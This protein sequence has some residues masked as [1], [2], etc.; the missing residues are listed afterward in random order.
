MSSVH[1]P[2]VEQA[3]RVVTPPQPGEESAGPPL[4]PLVALDDVARRIAEALGAQ[5]AAR[6]R[7]RE[8]FDSVPF[9]FDA[10]GDVT[11]ANAVKIW[12]VPQGNIGYLMR[13]MIEAGGFTPA[14]PYQ[15]AGAW[16]GIWVGRPSPNALTGAT[17]GGLVDYAP[18]A[19]GGPIFPALF[20]NESGSAPATHGPDSFYF[21]CEGS[22]TLANDAGVIWYRGIIVE[23]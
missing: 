10:N 9:S 2:Y 17:I 22:A 23:R 14:A 12:E 1:D 6:A 11:V 18:S 7:F 4:A 21:A 5:A 19:A 3:G 13:V 20:E 15:A 16:A 8:V